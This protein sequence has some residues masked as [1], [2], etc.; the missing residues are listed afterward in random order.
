MVVALPN[1]QRGHLLAV[2][3]AVLLIAVL[4]AGVMAPLM[5]FY[6][7]R[8][9]RLREREAVSAHMESLVAMLPALRERAQSA[10]QQGS[11]PLLTLEGGSDAVAAAT[12]QN[13]VQDMASS[14]GATLASVEIVPADAVR[15]YRRIGL[16][17]SFG[18]SWPVL[19]AL[20]QSVDQANLPL[21]VD[22]ISIHAPPVVPGSG[23]QTLDASF[24]I[25]A[26]RA[27]TSPKD[28]S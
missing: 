19:I 26:F 22:D 25:Y 20:L 23:P 5:G 1:G 9:E 17:F 6:E 7:S 8:S 13:I 15:Q 27:E 16:K 12:L 4:W 18:A 14:A 24:T 2:A 21:L 11:S 10:A 28:P 3:L